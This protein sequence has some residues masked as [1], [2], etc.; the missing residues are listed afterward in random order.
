MGMQAVGTVIGFGAAPARDAERLDAVALACEVLPA[1][2]P[3][4]KQTDGGS[5]LFMLLDDDGIPA[6]AAASKALRILKKRGGGEALVVLPA[7]PAL[8][9]PQARSRLARAAELSDACVVQPIGRASWADAVRCFVEPLAVFGL[10]GVDPREIHG[11]VR[12]RVAILRD[13][14]EILPEARELLISC[15]LRPNASLRELDDAA[16]AAAERAPKA[17]LI[18]AGPEVSDDGP[19]VIVASLL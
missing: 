1:E 9:G 19:Q 7:A 14:L 8:P 18:L 16:S 17:R 10:A 11:L 13:A 3:R 12:P 5:L 4:I 2:F 6:L 15:R